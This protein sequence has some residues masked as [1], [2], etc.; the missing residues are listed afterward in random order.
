MAEF[1]VRVLWVK[2]QADFS[3]LCGFDLV[4]VRH[5]HQVVLEGSVVV[6]LQAAGREFARH[7]L[8]MGGREACLG[9][10]AEVLADFRRTLKACQ[11]V[12]R[13]RWGHLHRHN[14]GSGLALLAIA[15]EKFG[16]FGSSDPNKY[17][18]HPDRDT[19]LSTS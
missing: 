8:D 3:R 13:E 4:L 1:R 16:L 2:L 12:P 17:E 5:V 10:P 6:V 18:P 15:R 9:I 19:G 14:G 7:N 11:R